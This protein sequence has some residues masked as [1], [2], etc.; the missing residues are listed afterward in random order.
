MVLGSNPGGGEIFH[1]RPELPWGPPCFLYSEFLFLSG[2]KRPSRCPSIPSS[3]EVKERVDAYLYS[4]SG[5]SGT[6]LGLGDAIR[7][8]S[9][10]ANKHPWLLKY[11]LFVCSQKYVTILTT[12]TC[13]ELC[14]Y[15]LIH[16]LF[17]KG[18]ITA[19][20][21]KMGPL[22]VEDWTNTMSRNVGNY[23]PIAAS[24]TSR[25][26]KTS[27]T[28][29]PLFLLNPTKLLSI[30]P[31]LSVCVIFIIRVVLPNLISI[32]L[33]GEDYKFRSS[34]LCIFLQPPNTFLISS[35]YLTFRW[36]NI[37]INSYNKT[38]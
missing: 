19:W 16:L 30:L 8:P 34:T 14:F 5:T 11:N 20:P 3:A 7:D 18:P 27:F 13:A 15:K 29:Q 33:F 22:S 17:F 23:L 6:V 1:T 32:I 2:S 36:L 25:R 24:L 21:L 37:V 12:I 9:I 28:L 4:L 35:C 38:N 31:L 10:H 26:A